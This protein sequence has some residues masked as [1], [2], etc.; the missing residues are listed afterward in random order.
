MDQYNSMLEGIKGLHYLVDED[1][2]NTI[3]SQFDVD[4]IPFYILVDRT[5]K[6]SP[7]PDFRDHTELI[8]GIKAAL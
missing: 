3:R 6:A 4:G 8:K 1:Q 2:I 5:G 7:H